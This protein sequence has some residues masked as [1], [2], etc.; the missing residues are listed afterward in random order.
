MK[1][2]KTSKPLS[3]ILEVF[4]FLIYRQLRRA[5]LEGFS[6][7]ILQSLIYDRIWTEIENNF[8]DNYS[9]I[10]LIIQDATR[11]SSIE[12]LLNASIDIGLL[13]SLDSIDDVHNAKIIKT[14]ELVYIPDLSETKS[15]ISSIS[16]IDKWKSIKLMVAPK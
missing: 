8:A 16:N 4:N 3:L 1:Y 15:T 13:F 9:G 11:E 7:N 2:S 12:H 5:N 14:T 6:L 10:E